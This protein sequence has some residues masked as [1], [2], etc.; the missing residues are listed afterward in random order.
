MISAFVSLFDH[1]RTQFITFILTMSML[2]IVGYYSYKIGR[3]Q[4]E[5]L[6]FDKETNQFTITKDGQFYTKSI[7][8]KIYDFF[9]I[10]VR[11]RG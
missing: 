1:N 9:N 4:L 10:F 7:S 2:F 8:H 11:E 3:K 6:L 5:T